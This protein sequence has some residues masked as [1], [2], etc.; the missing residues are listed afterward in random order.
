MLPQEQSVGRRERKR[1]RGVSEDERKEKKEEGEEE[2]KENA[3]WR[4]SRMQSPNIRIRA[5]LE[6]C[7]AAR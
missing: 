3:G 4:W 2:E 7:R 5:I 6:G 1:E